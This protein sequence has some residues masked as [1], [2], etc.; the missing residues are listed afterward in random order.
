MI[1]VT[2]SKVAVVPLENP[3]KIG[4]LWIPEI[5]KDRLNQGFVK[6][7][8]P[9]VVD[10]YVGQYVLFSGYTGT[11]VSVANEGKLI[12]IPEDF[13][14]AEL[15]QGEWELAPIPGV[16][17]KSRIDTGQ[18]YSELWKLMNE[19]LPGMDKADL[20][21]IVMQ[22][23]K[24]NITG[25]DSNPYFIANYEMIMEHVAHAYSENIAF[26][27]KL[28]MQ[29]KRLTLEDYDIERHRREGEAASI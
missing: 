24:R 16:Y 11:L 22:M 26:R 21:E 27:D 6:Y 4:L 9:D 5:A 28:R 3:D 18:Q 13:I 29:N 20:N 12:I 25:P 14:V 8:G 7:I 15:V 1:L 2:G 17:F 19:V 23:C 10:C